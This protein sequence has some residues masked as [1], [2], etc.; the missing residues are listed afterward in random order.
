[1]HL[2]MRGGPLNFF[3]SIQNLL[4]DP[5]NIRMLVYMTLATVEGGNLWTVETLCND[6]HYHSRFLFSFFGTQ[7]KH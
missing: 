1:M 5:S 6:F 3:R 4:M 2:E 7:Y